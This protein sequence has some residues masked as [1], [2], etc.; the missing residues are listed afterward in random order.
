MTSHQ[1]YKTMSWQNFLIKKK[2]KKFPNFGI[3]A[4][5]TRT[6]KTA[7]ERKHYFTKLIAQLCLAYENVCFK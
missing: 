2:K 4:M 6:K 3:V 1:T 7:K 5:E